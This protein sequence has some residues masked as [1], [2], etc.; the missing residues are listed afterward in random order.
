MPRNRSRDLIRI[1]DRDGWVCGICRDPARPVNRP[2][3]AVT[4]LASDLILEDV[5]GGAQAGEPW[6]AGS[7]GTLAVDHPVPGLAHAPQVPPAQA[8]CP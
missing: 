5:P 7:R 3:G 1:G 4:I 2:R 6:G 8:G